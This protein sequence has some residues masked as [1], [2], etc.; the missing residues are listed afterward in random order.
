M[1]T[2]TSAAIDKISV[3]NAYEIFELMLAAR[4]ISFRFPNGV[5]TFT[6]LYCSFELVF[7]KNSKFICKFCLMFYI[8]GMLNI[9]INEKP[10]YKFHFVNA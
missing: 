2:T 10:P 6:S 1:Q 9:H 4:Q 5:L 7:V 3:R 8:V